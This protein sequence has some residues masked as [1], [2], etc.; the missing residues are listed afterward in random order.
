MDMAMDFVL[1]IDRNLMLASDATVEGLLSRLALRPKMVSVFYRD[2]IS[3]FFDS[4]QRKDYLAGMHETMTKMYDVP[5]YTTR[6]LKKDTYEL[7]EPI[8]IFF[9]GGVPGK[10][11]SLI[12][13]SYFASGFIPRFLVVRGYG[14]T[15][16]IRP[17]GPPKRIGMDKR[18]Q[19]HSTFQALYSMYTDREVLFETH[20]GQKMMITPEIQVTMKDAVWERLAIMERQLLQAAEDS[21]EAERALPMFSRMYVSMQKLMMILAASRQEDEGLA[22]EAEMRDLL[23]AASYIQ[24][25]GRHAVD[26]IRNSGVTSDEN[27]LLSVYRTIEKHPGIMRSQVMQHHRLNARESDIIES[28]LHQRAMIQIVSKTA[29]S[30]Q[31]WPVGR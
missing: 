8:F 24:K 20:D 27:K 11:Y 1:D 14:T 30:K 15:E 6:V 23:K 18:T 19:L 7:V 5:P 17:T 26:L 22:I 21:P 28:T 25:W 13:E 9:G 16:K 12:D 29:K 10:M 4:M 3:G 2:E 31:Y